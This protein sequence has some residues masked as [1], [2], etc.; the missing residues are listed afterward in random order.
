VHIESE[1]FFMQFAAPLTAPSILLPALSMELFAEATE[2][3]DFSAT[4][5]ND[6]PL[7]MQQRI[8]GSSIG[9]I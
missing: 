5:A 2:L 4:L 8:R 1:S 3:Y 6:L 7:Q 9:R